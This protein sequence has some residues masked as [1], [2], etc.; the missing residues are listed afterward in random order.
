MS[1]VKFLEREKWGPRELVAPAA[2]PQMIT[3]VNNMGHN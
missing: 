2:N 1:S 3:R